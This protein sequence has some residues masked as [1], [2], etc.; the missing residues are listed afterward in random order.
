[1]AY[2]SPDWL[3]FLKDLGPVV[4]ATCTF[5]G[6]VFG[7]PLWQKRQIRLDMDHKRE[8]HEIEMEL[9]E[10]EKIAKE[11]VEFNAE[12]RKVAKDVFRQFYD[13]KTAIGIVRQIASYGEEI[14]ILDGWIANEVEIEDEGDQDKLNY[15]TRIK[16]SG[17]AIPY[18]RFKNQ[19]KLFVN[20]SKHKTDLEMYFES[21]AIISEINKCINMLHDAINYELIYYTEKSTHQSMV[22]EHNEKYHDKYHEIVW[23]IGEPD[24]EYEKLLVKTFKTV[25][26]MFRPFIKQIS[27]KPDITNVR[28]VKK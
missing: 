26:E 18:I 11:Q 3:L 6:V 14:K 17:L 12:K 15:W 25:D 1:M 24:S 27:N 8:K 2:V 13:I 4:I 22:V 19:Q 16:D 7:L 10:K 20:A 5:Y 28:S 21:S 9:L 23:G